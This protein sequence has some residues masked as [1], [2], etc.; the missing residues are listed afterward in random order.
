MDQQQGTIAALSEQLID[1]LRPPAG[2]RNHARAGL[3]LVHLT[4]PG[5]PD[6]DR[7][8]FV[9]RVVSLFERLPPI[10]RRNFAHGL[11]EAREVIQRR[12]PGVRTLVAM[13]LW[14]QLVARLPEDHGYL[15]R[16]GEIT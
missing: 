4:E 2:F 6:R 12:P 10:E 8:E 14:E 13:S 7:D 15:A 1:M 9:A 16:E 3:L 11:A 5:K